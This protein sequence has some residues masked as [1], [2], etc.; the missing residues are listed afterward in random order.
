M[1][2]FSPVFETHNQESSSPPPVKMRSV[3][4]NFYA[5]LVNVTW[6]STT[7]ED[8]YRPSHQNQGNKYKYNTIFS[9]IWARLGMVI[10][11]RRAE[12]ISK[13]SGGFIRHVIFVRITWRVEEP[14]VAL[15]WRQLANLIPECNEVR[16]NLCHMV[17]Q[18]FG[19]LA[20]HSWGTGE[21]QL[22]H[23]IE[24]SRA[25]L[26]HSWGIKLLGAQLGHSWGT[27]GA[28]VSLGH[29]WGRV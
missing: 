28:H 20:R 9:R 25:H 29:S 21:A 27:F 17:L 3:A 8:C 18:Q 5:V 14:V 23:K 12:N 1:I 11:N 26:G 19:N 13:F 2:G 16:L 10:I 24:N 4:S 6:L 22:G 15:S 7:S